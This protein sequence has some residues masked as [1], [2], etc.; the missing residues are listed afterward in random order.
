MRLAGFTL[1]EMLIV[2]AVLAALASA[3]VPLLSATDSQR[4]EL[5][6]TQLVQALRF[7][8]SEAQ[9]TSVPHGVRIDAAAE[10]VQVFRLN[11]GVVPPV[12]DFMIHHPVHRGLF[13]LNYRTDH[14]T[15]GV[16]IAAVTSSFGAACSE[17]RD[18]VFDQRGTPLCSNPVTVGLTSATVDLSDGRTTR[19]VTVAGVTGRVVLQ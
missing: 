8:R 14:V 15:A 12:R 9:H 5:A 18:L 17:F 19:R 7:A 10:T 13:V 2:V 1:T 11:T 6:A 3:A 16:E 4:V